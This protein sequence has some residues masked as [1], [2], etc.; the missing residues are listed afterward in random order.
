VSSN[1]YSHVS[2][3]FSDMEKE[4]HCPA[5]E[6]FRQMCSSTASYWCG[7][8]H[9]SKGSRQAYCSRDAARALLGRVIMSNAIQYHPFEFDV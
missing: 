9:T 2:G 8:N 3:Q 1:L 5:D 7:K 6:I 4:L